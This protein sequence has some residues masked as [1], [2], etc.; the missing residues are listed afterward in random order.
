MSQ[1]KEKLA[2]WQIVA[3]AVILPVMAIYAIGSAVF[4]M[5]APNVINGL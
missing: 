3:L 4:F 5:F 1:G 2:R